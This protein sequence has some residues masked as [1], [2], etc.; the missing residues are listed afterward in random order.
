MTC[1]SPLGSLMSYLD[2]MRFV[3]TQ[4][5]V[6]ERART[7]ALKAAQKALGSETPS[8]YSRPPPAYRERDEFEQNGSTSSAAEGDNE[9]PSLPYTDLPPL[10]APPAQQGTPDL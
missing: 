3:C 8:Y 5:E 2:D 10:D 6:Q 4:D 9:L 7:A 1:T